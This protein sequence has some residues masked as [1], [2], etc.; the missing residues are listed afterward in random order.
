MNKQQSKLQTALIETGK[1]V[2]A[3]NMPGMPELEA[4]FNL[5]KAAEQKGDMK[6]MRKHGRR[7][8]ALVVKVM[9]ERL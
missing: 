8:A 1:E 9:V 4:E 2:E 5:F 6:G 3:L 7:L